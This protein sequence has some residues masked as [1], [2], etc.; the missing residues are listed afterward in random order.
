MKVK[1]RVPANGSHVIGDRVYRSGE[2]FEA[3][4]VDVAQYIAL[5][6]LEQVKKPKQKKA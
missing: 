4:L 6:N 1:V 2:E 3:E 5:G